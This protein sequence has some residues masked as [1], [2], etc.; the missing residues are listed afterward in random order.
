MERLYTLRLPLRTQCA[1]A[2]Y[3]RV[4]RRV[5]PA[6]ALLITWRDSSSV[7][8]ANTT[9]PP[10]YCPLLNR[11]W[12]GSRLQ[13]LIG[14]RE[15]AMTRVSPRTS[16]GALSPFPAA[17]YAR[18]RSTLLAGVLSLILC[19]ASPSWGQMDEDI[20]QGVKKATSQLG[21]KFVEIRR[22]V[23]GVDTLAVS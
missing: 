20:V 5:P 4:E 18:R 11:Y 9:R 8:S 17:E 16:D 1:C 6:T 22:D 3:I 2:N 13:R 10:L 15:E 12:T 19:L 21:N 23:L 7:E 14:L